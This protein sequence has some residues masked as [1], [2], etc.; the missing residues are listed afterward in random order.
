MQSNQSIKQ[1]ASNQS[2]NQSIQSNQYNQS[3]QSI[4]PI[5]QINQPIQSIQ[6]INRINHIN[7][8]IKS[9]KSIKPIN[10]INTI[11][12]TNT[13][14][15]TIQNEKTNRI[16][17][18]RHQTYPIQTNHSTVPR[19]LYIATTSSPH[20]TSQHHEHAHALPQTRRSRFIYPAPIERK[21]PAHA[22]AKLP[23]PGTMLCVPEQ[24]PWHTCQHAR[25]LTCCVSMIMIANMPMIASMVVVACPRVQSWS[26]Q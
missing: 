4:N 19:A 6:S 1:I 18:N 26:E 21:C 12:P 5:N 17:A 22:W 13:L 16:Q 25:S 8:S 15:Q 3:D 10:P 2:I 9:I 23:L 14:N 24:R 20:Q 11:N 7:K